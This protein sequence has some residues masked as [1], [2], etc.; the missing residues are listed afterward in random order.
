MK[1]QKLNVKCC[2]TNR[3]QYNPNQHQANQRPGKKVICSSGRI[4]TMTTYA[5][6]NIN[7]ENQVSEQP[8]PRRS[9]TK[10]QFSVA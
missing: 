3:Q 6:L 5:Y 8:Q 10:G 9:F 4:T 7:T 1:L 2:Q